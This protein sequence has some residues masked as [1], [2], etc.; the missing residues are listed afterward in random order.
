MIL[1]FGDPVFWAKVAGMVDR[2]IG[3]AAA[4]LVSVLV[5]LGVPGPHPALAQ[6]PPV[7]ETAPLPPVPGN[8]VAPSRAP[9]PTPLPTPSPTPDPA[10]A[11]AAP[12]TPVPAT[13]V[14]ATPVP[15]PSPTPVPTGPPPTAPPPAGPLPQ[16][17]TTLVPPPADPST[18]DE[19][20]LAPKPA[21][22]VRGSSSWDDGYAKLTEVFAKLAADLS[23]AGI[24]VAGKPVAIFVDTDDVGFRYEALLPIEAQPATRPAALPAEIEFGSTP[25]GKAIRFAHQAAYD[26][27]D[28]TYEAVTAYLDSKGI[29]VKDAFIEEYVAFGKDAA[30]PVLQ[31]YIYVQPK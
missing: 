23:L 30:D 20:E 26:E 5:L 6:T 28:G 21:A 19:V 12:S 2:F 22:V 1:G 17:G 31:L 25:S 7:V 24:P 14:P 3:T 16:S 9:D 18:S 8:P 10:P 27:I 4:L 29:E 15:A 13:P 11:P